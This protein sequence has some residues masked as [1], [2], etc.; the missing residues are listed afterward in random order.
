MVVVLVGAGWFVYDRLR[1]DLN[2]RINAGL[3]ARADAVSALS[4][5]RGAPL[6][7][8]ATAGL[9]EPGE[10][11]AQILGPHGRVAASAGGVRGPA[12]SSVEL[13]R[14]AHGSVVLERE[15][16]GTDGT[17]RMLA[18]PFRDG[19]T[20]AVLVVGQALD[21]R[22]EALA[23]VV[24]SFAVGGPIAVALAS[25]IGY[26]LAVA[27]FRPVEAMRR[28]AGDVALT[29]DDGGLPLPATR[30]EVRRL[31][32]TLNE[33]LDRLR[34]AA[35]RERRFVADASHELRTPIAVIKTELENALRIGDYG[36]HVRDALVAAAEECD[37]LAQ[38]ADDLLVIARAADGE[39]PVRPEPLRAS[40]VLES[41]R[42]RFVDRALRQ[43]R[44]IDIDAEPDVE[45]QA[46]PVRLRQALGNL[47]ENALRHGAGDIHLAARRTGTAV[48]L[49][50]SDE[51]RGFPPEIATCAFERFTHNHSGAGSGAGLGMAIVRA[52]AEAHGGDAAIVPA[53]RTTVRIWLPDTT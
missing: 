30:D 36:P 25:A 27:A 12:L 4:G 48:E 2:D 10:S 45:L 23:G 7:T 14:A 3:A 32:E 35:E 38:L 47:V 49:D 26:L 42:D 22:D 33:M 40:T 43:D 44:R 28:R 46:D 24:R 6:R 29:G 17:A 51:G 18:R 13:A 41:V 53:P 21:D 52:I 34:R 20:V 31:G 9:V 11:F 50:V 16:A 39:L 5:R 1:T 8:L 15:V 37:G 19:G